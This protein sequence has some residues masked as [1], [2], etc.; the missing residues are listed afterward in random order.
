MQTPTVD[1]RTK[2][3]AH[4]ARSV[5][6]GLF[7][8][9]VVLANGW[10]GGHGLSVVRFVVVA[11]CAAAAWFLVG[12]GSGFLWSYLPIPRDPRAPR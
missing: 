6:V 5:S 12:G 1:R 3:R 10:A 4:A 8:A 9:W 7:S 11:V 2:L